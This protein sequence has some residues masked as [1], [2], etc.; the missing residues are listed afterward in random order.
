MTLGE[1]IL[2]IRLRNR[3]SQEAFGEMLGTTRQSVSKW[4]RD[5]ALPELEKIVRMSELF[6]VT[7]DYIL[8]DGVDTFASPDKFTCRV[9]RSADGEI[10]L[11]E[12]FALHFY[13]KSSPRRIG[14]LL[15]KGSRTAKFCIAAAEHDFSA[16][17]TY[18]C[19]VYANGAAWSFGGGE[20]D[21]IIGTEFS[22]KSAAGMK[23]AETFSTVPGER[24]M[25]KVSDV[26]IAGAMKAWRMGAEFTNGGGLCS[27]HLCTAFTEYTF[28][29][30]PDYGDV[31]IGASWNIPFEMGLFGG[32][33]YFRIRDLGERQPYCGFG[34]NF[35]SRRADIRIPTE[36]AAIGQCVLTDKGYLWCVKRYDDDE[37]V[38][39][40]C[41]GDEYTFR[42]NVE[43]EERFA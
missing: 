23:T 36:K 37:I 33:Q 25:P 39:E 31:Y 42:R 11:T 43:V 20:L 17:R 15:Y 21:G 28:D 35:T 32:Q 22:E 18:A 40:G 24:E 29:I 5:T 2:E 4:E 7:T 1:R 19:G 3:L 41:G 12:K 26:G 14:C 30:R 27:L 34:A 13:E 8:R 6:S 9:M 16:D 38:L 10:V